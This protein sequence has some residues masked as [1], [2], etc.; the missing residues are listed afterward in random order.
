[1]GPFFME[2][3]LNVLHTSLLFKQGITL[4]GD[5]LPVAQS[6]RHLSH[7]VAPGHHS[8]L[9]EHTEGSPHPIGLLSMQLIQTLNGPRQFCCLILYPSYA[10]F[11]SPS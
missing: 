10:L 1:M 6:L 3:F 8:G 4:M 11:F 5:F 9:S 7:S 2:T